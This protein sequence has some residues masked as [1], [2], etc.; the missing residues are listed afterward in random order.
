[1]GLKTEK[2]ENPCIR[3]FVGVASAPVQGLEDLALF[4]SGREEGRFSMGVLFQ[5]AFRFLD[6]PGAPSAPARASVSAPFPFRA[7]RRICYSTATD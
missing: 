4:S 2:K 5:Y 3:F 1:M 6:E 7:I